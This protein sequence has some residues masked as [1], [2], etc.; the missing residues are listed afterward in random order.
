MKIHIQKFELLTNA[1]YFT[2]WLHGILGI[3][4]LFYKQAVAFFLFTKMNNHQTLV[5]YSFAHY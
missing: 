1:K 2:Y 3:S 5:E 4:E